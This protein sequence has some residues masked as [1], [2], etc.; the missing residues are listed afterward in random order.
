[1]QRLREIR[2]NR[3]EEE[4]EAE[5]QRLREIRRNMSKEESARERE[6]H[7]ERRRKRT[8]ER[9]EI[10]RERLREI[11]RK[12]CVEQHEA[13]IFPGKIT[14]SL[15]CCFAT[16]SRKNLCSGYRHTHL[17]AARAIKMIVTHDS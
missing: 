7:R 9:R 6:R 17:T 14:L 12:S 4:R 13:R 1:M 10:E 5:L 15:I 8:E 11:R 3:T 2:S 16:L